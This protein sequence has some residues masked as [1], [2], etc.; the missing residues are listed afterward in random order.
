MYSHSHGLYSVFPT[1]GVRRKVSGAD[2]E[3][4]QIQHYLEIPGEPPRKLSTQYCKQ[5]QQDKRQPFLY[6]II[7][8]IQSAKEH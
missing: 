4:Y 7:I 3:E 6:G 2:V 8:Q 5:L 1:T